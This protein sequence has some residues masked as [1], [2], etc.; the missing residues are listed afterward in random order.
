MA[1]IKCIY[2][3]V[4]GTIAN[5]D[6]TEVVDLVPVDK[7]GELQAEGKEYLIHVCPACAASTICVLK[8]KPKP[9]KTESKGEG[10]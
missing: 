3:E 5:P 9:K 2:C 6:G 7:E 4:R 1:E 10:G 8:K